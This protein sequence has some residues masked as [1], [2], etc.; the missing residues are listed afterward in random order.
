M[1][2]NKFVET[3]V[4]LGVDKSM[5]EVDKHG[6]VPLYLQVKDA[7]RRQIE[8]GRYGANDP[9]PQERVLANELGMNRLTVRRAMVELTQEGLLQRVRGRG[10][11]ISA[12][13]IERLNGTASP[14][15]SAKKWTVAI[16]S[17]FE[18]PGEQTDSLF[19]SRI[20]RSIYDSCGPDVNFVYRKALTLENVTAL[21]SEAELSG[22]LA[23]SYEKPAFIRALAES[24]KPVTIID[25]APLAELPAN[26]DA[27]CFDNEESSFRAVSS[28]I[29]SGHTAIMMMIHSSFEGGRFPPAQLECLAASGL[30]LG[31]VPQQRLNG[32]LRAFRTHG[33]PVRDELIL[34][35]IPCAPFG[36]TAMQTLLNR[37]TAPTALFCSTDELAHGAIAAVKDFGWRVPE[38]LSVIGFGDLGA[39]CT[40]A[41]SSV[42]MPLEA[43]GTRA[44]AALR[45][46]IENPKLPPRTW[47]LPTEFIA[48]ASCGL[49]R[50]AT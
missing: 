2:F 25:T 10:T 17:Q 49:P 19:Y 31:A 43:A 5:I 13:V 29:R 40:P 11:F 3:Q 20:F 23:V 16:A 37:A 50:Q 28:L 6:P 39:F 1:A 36:Y 42:R 45:E 38:H 47:N 22:I 9:L 48:R 14:I 21:A 44:M 46:R 8:S 15:A 27:I 26:C 24:G 35:V 30:T 32:Y 34:P 4:Y 41:L 12:T 18:A 7:I 33:L